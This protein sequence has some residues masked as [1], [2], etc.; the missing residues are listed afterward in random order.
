MNIETIADTETTSAGPVV[1]RRR[2][3]QRRRASR[4]ISTEDLTRLIDVID[5]AR[6]GDF[7]ARVHATDDPLMNEL[8]TRLNELVNKN[9]RMLNEIERVGIAVGQEGRNA[10]RAVLPGA[11]RGWQVQIESVNSLIDDM[12]RPTTEVG[13][14]LDAVARGDL[15]RKVALTIEGQPVKGEYLRIGTTVNA[16][17]DQLSSFSDEVTRVAR[18]VGT[19]GRLGGQAEVRGVS[20]VWRDLTDN[21]NLMASNLTTQVRGIVRVVTAVAEGDLEQKFVLEAEGEVAGLAETINDMIDK[22]R[23]FS[24]QVTE[25][26]REVGTEGQLGGQADV[27]GVSGT[28]KALTDSVNS[29]ASNL[30]DQVRDIA[31]VTTAVANGDLSQKITSDARGEIAELK[32][33]INTMVDQLREFAGEVS[34]VAR[35]VGT[36]GQ[37]GGQAEVRGVSG[38]WKDLTDNVNQ[39]ADNLTGQV[40]NIAQVTTAVANGDLTRKITVEAR[41]EIAE[42]K[43]T[44]NTMVDQLSSFADEVTRVAKEVGTDGKLGGQAHVRG[45]S[46]TWKDL[47]ENVNQL[48]GNLTTQVRAIAEVSTAVTAGDLSREITVEAS[49]EVADLKNNINQMI[50]NLAHTTRVNAEQDWLNVNLARFSSLLQG[51]RDLQQIAELIMRELT[52]LVG[53]QHGAFFVAQGPEGPGT[54]Q[55]PEDVELHLL[56]TWGLKERR[57]AANSFKLGE[58]LVGQAALEQQRITIEQAPADYVTVNSGLGE[59]HP[60]SIV[61]VPMLFENSVMGVVELG[62]FTGFDEGHQNLLDQLVETIGVVLNTIVANTRTERLLEQSNSLA[63]ELRMQSNELQTQQEELRDSNM[64]LEQQAQTLKASEELLQAQQEE[65]QQ[66]N[67][68]LEEKATLLAEQYQ[69]IEEKN[70]DIELART[71][72]EDKASQLALSSRYKSEF[73]ANM[74]HELR[75]PLNS[76]LIL[77]KLLGDNVDGNLSER[78]VQFATTIYG[79]GND[80]LELINDILDLSKVEAGKMDVDLEEVSLEQLGER[81]REAFE[82]IVQEQGLTLEIELDPDAGNEILSDG[83]RV[84]Q[85]LKNLLSNACK[86]T[87]HGTV[88]LRIAPAAPGTPFSSPHLHD[89][90]DVIALEVSD[91]GIGIPA[92]KLRLIF[93][94]FQQ[95]EG[96]I[97]R[98]YGGTGLGLSISREIARLLGGELHAHSEQ[99]VGSTF[100]LYLPR[101][102]DVDAARSAGATIDDSE[103]QTSETAHR[104]STPQV[105]EPVM[106]PD[107]EMLSVN[108]LDDDR[109][110][111]ADGDRV[112]LVIE[113]DE[114]FARTMMDFARDR[115]YRVI[116]ATRGDVGWALA[117]EYRPDAITLD[118]DLPDVT[119]WSVLDRLKHHPSTRHIPIHVV[120]AGEGRGHALRAGASAYLEKP[121]SLDQLE[122][123]FEQLSQSVTRDIRYVLVVEDDK[124]EREAI[125]ELI[126]DGDDVDATAVASAETAWKQLQSDREFD[127]MV[128]DLKLPKQGGFELL[129]QIRGDER[130]RDMPIIVYTGRDLTRDEDRRL[131]E[132]AA[133]IIVKDARSPERLLD[134]TAL[135]LHRVEAR[136]P[137]E[138]RRMLERLKDG[139]TVLADKRVLIVDDDVRNVFALTSLLEAYDMQVSYAENGREGIEALEKASF[140]LVL[141]D[142]MMPEMDGYE[143]TAAIR[144]REEWRQLPIIA[145]TAKAMKG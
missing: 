145:L 73:L 10:E 48:A 133:S 63:D 91:T 129:E 44:I 101:S 33:T 82:P 36:E 79:S 49:G 84:Q 78:Q 32:G 45:V 75:T 96:G 77:S 50:A 7:S 127:C 68:E 15:T 46:G 143:T 139:D 18:E 116:G 19:E 107:P 102:W 76:L 141:M 55:E 64:E 24:E 117:H 98:R 109:D 16:M 20:G 9:E 112:L 134:E 106:T 88:K 108:Q 100:T 26:A 30:T 57:H 53:A 29:M 110:R 59:A 115:G 89:S 93:E 4:R 138:R 118:I 62:S 95:A 5:R 94:A 51:Q 38:T 142:V 41:G 52:P 74:S 124:T 135:F 119:G 83:R 99:G 86:F 23:R 42:L 97:A 123:A 125:V 47:T 105:L 11:G 22:L 67:E 43:E 114:T 21:V 137:T 140:D 39:L 103:V 104:P 92:E 60:M 66:T 81:T 121:L 80:L 113:D 12:M 17:V 56:A 14:V 8:G 126:A 111:I 58:G 31:V 122:D 120:S 85:V 25:V 87:E 34:R 128:L 144:E 54:A 1:E 65:L 71:E 130:L 2:W 69:A 37:L 131:R 6:S 132:L 35:E 136:M 70:R 3:W 90:A 28:W 13:R 72:L 40:R 61:L 27:P